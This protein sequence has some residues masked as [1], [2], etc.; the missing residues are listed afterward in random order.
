MD[1]L[2]ATPCQPRD[3][4]RQGVT[5]LTPAGRGSQAVSPRPRRAARGPA[6]FARD[7]HLPTPCPPSGRWAPPPPRAGTDGK[8]R[9]VL[10]PR[11]TYSTFLLLPLH[12]CGK[13]YTRASP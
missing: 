7:F 9:A 1:P 6:S 11:P 13:N 2:L 3:A 12:G 10:I 4:Y 5:T 8:G